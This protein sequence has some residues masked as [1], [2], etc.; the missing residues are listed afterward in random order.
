MKQIFRIF[1][2]IAVAMLTAGQ[3]WAGSTADLGSI[4]TGTVT[5]GTLKFYKEAT[6]V[7][8]ISINEELYSGDLTE[9]TIY[10]KATPNWNYT[11][12]NV[13]FTAQVSISSSSLEARA[14]TRGSTSDLDIGEAITVSAVSGKPGVYSFTMPDDGKNVT[15]N[16]TFNQPTQQQVTYIDENFVSQTVNAYVLDES[17]KSLETGKFY[18]VTRDLTINH[19]IESPSSSGTLTIIVPDGKT[20]TLNTINLGDGL[21]YYDY[22]GFHFGCNLSFYGQANATG[23]VA[24]YSKGESIG[25]NGALTVAHLNMEVASSA[26][27]AIRAA[28]GVLYAGHKTSGNSLTVRSAGENSYG[29]GIIGGGNPVTIKNCD[30]EVT[31]YAKSD[32]EY[33]PCI[34]CG[35]YGGG[36]TGVT[37]TGLAN[38]NNKVKIRSKVGTITNDLCNGIYSS[39]APVTIKNCDVDIIHEGNKG[40]GAG[41]SVTIEGVASGNKVNTLTVRSKSYGIS[42][43][44]NYP[45]NISYCDVEVTG[46]QSNNGI[47]TP[48]DNSGIYS[49][50]SSSGG[51]YITGRADGSNKVVIRAGGSGCINGGACPVSI[52]YC[53]V[54]I[55][56]TGGAGIYVGGSSGGFTFE[57]VAEGETVNKLTVRSSAYGI[58]AGGSPV[59][60]KN[61]DVEV[62]GLNGDDL[63]SS[64][65]FYVTYYPG[66]V[67]TGRTDRK[68]KIIVRSNGDAIN[69]GGC[70]ASIKYCDVDIFANGSGFNV[71]GGSGYFE[72]VASGTVNTITVRSNG[73][74]GGINIGGSSLTIKYYDVEVT[75]TTKNDAGAYNP[76]G[77]CGIQATTGGLNIISRTDVV[78]KIF[79]RSTYSAI[80]GSGTYLDIQNCDVDAVSTNSFGLGGSSDKG[81]SITSTLENGNTI[82]VKSGGLGIFSGGNNLN[83]TNCTVDVESAATAVQAIQTTTV[84]I[85]DSKLT[86]TCTGSYSGS[87]K[88]DYCGINAPKGL[89]IDGSQVTVTAKNGYA[90]IATCYEG[91]GTISDEFKYVTFGWKNATD[92]IKVDRYMVYAEYTLSI[93]DGKSFL[94]YTP[95]AT[96]SDPMTAT[97]VISG[98]VIDPTTLNGKTLKPLDGYTVTVADD[99][100]LMDGTTA[101][102]PDF[103][104]G[105]TPYYIY[106]ASTEQNPV[107]VTLSYGGTD[108][109]TVGGLP[110]GTTLDDVE[111]QPMQRSFAMPAENLALTA[112]A[113]TPVKSNGDIVYNGSA[114]TPDFTDGTTAMTLGTDYS[115]AVT[116]GGEA[117]S[118][119]INVGTDYAVTL[120]GLGQ[121]VGTTASYDFSI[122]Q[123][124]VAIT[125]DDVS[126]GTIIA[127]TGSIL[128]PEVTV[129]YTEGETTTALAATDFTVSYQKQTSTDPVTYEDVS[130]VKDVGTYVAIVTATIDGNYTFAAVTSNPFEVGKPTLTVKAD[131]INVE[132]GTFSPTYT[133]TYTGFINGDTETDL[134]GTLSFACD[135]TWNSNTGRTYVIT[136]GGLTSDK[137]DISYQTGTLTVITA[138]IDY[139]GGT[140]TLDENGYDITLDEGAGSANP[141]PSGTIDNLDYSR[142]LAAP[143]TGEG[144]AEI[145]GE[146]ANLYTVCLP[147]APTSTAAKYY[148][149]N[150]VEGTTLKFTEINGSPAAFTPYLVAVTGNSDVVVSCSNV[151]FDTNKAI[152]NTTVNGFTFTGTL[153]GLSNAAAR[154]TAGSGN[155]TYIL[156]NAA[157]WGKVVS[158]SVYL[159]PFRAYIVG[160]VPAA[161]ARELGSSFDD[162]NATAIERIVTTDRDGTEHWYDMNGRRIE[163]PTTKG[164]YILNGRKE[165]IK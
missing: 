61:S 123:K 69:T 154:A 85:T 101:K 134:D 39:S 118:G 14:I 94:A 121:Y 15:V 1:T 116:K 43:N 64:Y 130:E 77:G 124:A 125:A 53:D 8:E 76:C 92:F 133:A 143:G 42:S 150:S 27:N 136:P 148:T 102:T 165:V 48:C 58:N 75:G 47:Y 142:T 162:G 100:S 3:A 2:L 156:Q 51:I 11:G 112:T 139:I 155:V 160:P 95:G 79:V 60:I 104:I 25:T 13:T 5:N 68:N 17:M 163:K 119:A 49:S 40:I 31:G 16:A 32:G 105:T 97:A 157:K 30:V 132:Y 84:S 34:G 93:A 37:I 152:S 22:S 83:I 54:D 36:S 28:G 149:L 91:S 111:N 120:T 7:N 161:G 144:D 158:G 33:V 107:T 12:V 145:G 57:G 96:E 98:T 128:S 90:G 109:V 88:S 137:Y 74:S 78:N 103:T 70:P 9:G 66:L 146:A 164:V 147:K 129:S 80:M 99:I 6:C 18:V 114:Q 159:P 117:V 38:G 29:G 122:V 20:F 106:K 81:L 10:I 131:N 141:L 19:D 26:A 89:T 55:Y 113:V 45:V 108:F 46:F 115:T 62:T 87:Y 52:K 135:Y 153:A 41:K 63:C 72:G 65:G 24:I 59:T 110:E 140:I 71:G 4:K 67:I 50:G 56:N 151:S 23:K 86:A 126:V 21:S 73:I 138:A 82:K 35:I 127:Y 44:N